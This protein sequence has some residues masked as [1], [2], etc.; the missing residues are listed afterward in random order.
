MKNTYTSA[1]VNISEGDKFVDAIKPL[2]KTTFSQNVVSG[3]GNF[4]AFFKIPKKLK[5]PV[6]V[7]STDGVGTKLKIAV[8]AKKHDT[9]GEDLVNH[10]VNDIAVCGA[11]PLFF[12]DYMAFGK[13]RSKIAIDI[14]KGLVR[15]CRNN[16]ASLIGGETAEMPGLYAKDDYYVAGTKLGV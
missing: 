15:G 2:V 5:N 13:L 12:L 9:I 3:I 6:F 11:A 8:L 10:C 1:G 7:A 4:G 14:V 16:N